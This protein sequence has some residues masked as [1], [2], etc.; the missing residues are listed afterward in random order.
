MCMC[1]CKQLLVRLRA[2]VTARKLGWCS[3]I[4]GQV[5][6]GRGGDRKVEGVPVNYAPAPTSTMQH[7]HTFIFAEEV[8]KYKVKPFGKASA[9]DKK[10][11]KKNAGGSKNDESNL[12]PCDESLVDKCLRVIAQN[13]ATRPRIEGLPETLLPRL[14]DQLSLTLP[15]NI[16]AAHVH[17]ESYW[18]RCCLE[19][20]GWRNCQIAEHGLTWKQT[21]FEKF[22]HHP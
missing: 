13:F 11:N 2:C 20:K 12:R 4:S 14:V 6:R 19:G 21:F 8:K 22:I 10:K 18:K 17:S 3:L 9:G 16:S 1:T 7:D 5:L 15:V